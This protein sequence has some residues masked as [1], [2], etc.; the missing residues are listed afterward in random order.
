VTGIIDLDHTQTWPRDLIAYLETHYDLIANWERQTSLVSAQDYDRTICGL[1]DVLK[2]YALTGWHCTRLTEAEIAAINTHGMQLP[3]V[4]MLRRRIDDLKNNGLI[5]AQ[6]AERLRSKN[7]AHEQNRQGKIWFCFFPPYI[8]GESGIESLLRHW[9][10]E[11]LYNSHDRDPETGPV[12]R[13]IGIP[14][15]VEADVPIASLGKVGPAFN[16]TLRFLLSRG[17]EVKE[18]LEYEG[19]AERALPEDRIRRII[20]FPDSEFFALTKADEWNLPL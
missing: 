8:A 17:F 9:G 19:R 15:L 4:E 12:L 5:T 6:I 2:N 10:G 13:T 1:C 3:N 18:R 7:Q 14:C 11:A 20:R 16:I